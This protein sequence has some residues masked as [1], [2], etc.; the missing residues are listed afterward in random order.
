MPECLKS[1]AFEDMDTLER[2]KAL[3]LGSS[4]TGFFVIGLVENAVSFGSLVD[5]ALERPL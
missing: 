2:F 5:Q 3:A 4:T 1:L